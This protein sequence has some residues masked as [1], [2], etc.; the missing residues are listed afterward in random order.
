MKGEKIAARLTSIVNF[1]TFIGTLVKTYIYF[2]VN[3][4]FHLD[5]AF[6]QIRKYQYE[7]HSN[8]L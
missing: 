7:E 6:I 5:S 1:Y 2:S 3:I 8:F 4:N